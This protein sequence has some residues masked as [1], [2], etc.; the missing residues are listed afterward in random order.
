[1]KT[2]NPRNHIYART[3]GARALNSIKMICLAKWMEWNGMVQ[4]GQFAL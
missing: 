1:M 3:A 2:I 4:S